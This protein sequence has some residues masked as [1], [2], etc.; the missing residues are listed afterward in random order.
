MTFDLWNCEEKRFPPYFFLIDYVG[1]I[2]VET[3]CNVPGTYFDLVNFNRSRMT[4]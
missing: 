2:K 3:P 4:P 1:F